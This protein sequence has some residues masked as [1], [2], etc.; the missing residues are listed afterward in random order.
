MFVRPAAVV[1]GTTSTVVVEIGIVG[2]SDAVLMRSI[3]DVISGCAIMA[4][5]EVGLDDMS[6]GGVSASNSKAME[7]VKG[8]GCWGATVKVTPCLSNQSLGGVSDTAAP[9]PM[10]FWS[11]LAELI[12]LFVV[13]VVGT[14]VPYVPAVLGT[15]VPYV[16][17][18]LVIIVLYV[19]AV[20]SLGIFFLRRG[21][22][23]S[24]DAMSSPEETDVEGPASGLSVADAA[25]AAGAA[26]VG[27]V[28]VVVV[29]FFARVRLA[30]LV[31]EVVSGATMPS[32]AG[33]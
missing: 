15:V 14:V 30:F 20:F 8:A 23:F 18:V 26:T 1:E 28:V 11:S 10:P 7:S 24:F 5:G 27:A 21:R 3:G 16:P 32:S 25:D 12:T 22:G 19:P 31:V 2:T 13:A 29:T 6:S 9:P 33:N 4:D 17:A